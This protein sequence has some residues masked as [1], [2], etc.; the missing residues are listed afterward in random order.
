MNKKFVLIVFV[1]LVGAVFLSACQ[2]DVGARLKSTANTNKAVTGGSDVLGVN[3]GYVE[4][5]CGGD[6]GCKAEL[7]Q[8]SPSISEVNCVAQEGNACTTGCGRG[9]MADTTGKELTIG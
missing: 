2:S 6:G 8:V 3:P 1:L 4:C 9:I 5:P 7:K